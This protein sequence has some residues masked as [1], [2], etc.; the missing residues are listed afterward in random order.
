MPARSAAG[1]GT[2]L[3]N[4]SIRGGSGTAVSLE[5]VSGLKTVFTWKTWTVSLGVG[6]VGSD[7]N[8]GETKAP[9]PMTHSHP[10]GH[11]Q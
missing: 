2:W 4:P 5:G 8:Y 11:K 7:G 3:W 1:R 6:P 9:Q 10:P